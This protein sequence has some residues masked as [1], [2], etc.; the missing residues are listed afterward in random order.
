MPPGGQV[1]PETH[2]NGAI[3]GLVEL[4]PDDPT[5]PTYTGTYREKVNGVLTAGS[6]EDDALRV[7]QYRLTTRLA[8]SDGSSLVLR[9]SGKLTVN[10]QG[11]V[12]VT[13]DS[14]GCG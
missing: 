14:F 9:L 10:A 13:R 2:L 12:A 1:P 8:G 7:G 6:L 5:L 11:T 4:V 3:D